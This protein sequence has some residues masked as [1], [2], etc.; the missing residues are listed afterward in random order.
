MIRTLLVV[1]L[2][3]CATGC[4]APGPA[5]GTGASAEIET[6]SPQLA[7]SI[8]EASELFSKKET[9]L[10]AL[11]WQMDFGKEENLWAIH[12]E[13]APN[14]RTAVTVEILEGAEGWIA[15]AEYFSG[16][17][18]PL[19]LAQPVSPT[20]VAIESIEDAEY[21][22]MKEVRFTWAYSDTPDFLARLKPQLHGGPY[23]GQV[24]IQFQEDSWEVVGRVRTTGI[25]L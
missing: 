13:P 7:Q 11:E 4:T 23:V 14:G 16:G 9:T 12:K 18:V 2:L 1:G 10:H 8:I 22:Q 25:P 20:V 19:N 3:A 6:L 5:D 21:P 15:S 17:V 24:R